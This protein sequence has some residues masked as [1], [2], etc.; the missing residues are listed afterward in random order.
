MNTDTL[1]RSEFRPSIRQPVPPA[2]TMPELPHLDR[3]VASSRFADRCMERYALRARLA[4]RPNVPA[5]LP[6]IPVDTSVVMAALA[7]L[8]AADAQGCFGR[9]DGTPSATVRRMLVPL[10]DERRLAVDV[11]PGL[12]RFRQ[13]D[14]ARLLQELIANA[15][16]HSPPGATSR[17]RGAPGAGGYQLSVTNPGQRLPRAAV[18]LLRPG[19]RTGED[20]GALG[21]QLGLSIAGTL[22]MLNGSRLE[23]LRGAGRPNTLR[24]IVP[25]A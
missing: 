5:E 4:E 9:F 19:H 25:T 12:I 7:P 14:L 24:F 1:Q 23:V 11:V 2:G 15:W 20:D 18:A 13:A 16:R 17:L 3:R 10:P 8:F 22:A 21:V 6:A